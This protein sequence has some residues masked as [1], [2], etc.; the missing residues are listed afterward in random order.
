MSTATLAG[1]LFDP[2]LSE[3]F[4]FAEDWLEQEGPFYDL[5]RQ[6]REE[7]AAAE[8]AAAVVIDLTGEEP[9]VYTHLSEPVSGKDMRRSQRRRQTVVHH[10]RRERVANLRTERIEAE[11]RRREKA[12]KP[13]PV[14]AELPDNRR[15]LSK[16]SLQRQL[17]TAEQS[18][19]ALR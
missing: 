15:E 9:A 14:L 2:D 13:C 10:R 17:S 8:E 6:A 5:M 12:G 1:H 4:E 11:R 3:D 18:V 19:L 16:R 7:V